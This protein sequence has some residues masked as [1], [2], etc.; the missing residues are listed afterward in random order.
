MIR[1]K[2]LKTT[3]RRSLNSPNHNIKSKKYECTTE[4]LQE[5][6]EAFNLFDNDNSGR[7]SKPNIG[8]KSSF[9]RLIGRFAIFR[10]FFT[11]N[12]TLYNLF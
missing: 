1:K 2:S 4:E 8:N 9:R 7:I 10:D 3:N 6:K 11:L 12:T 5:V